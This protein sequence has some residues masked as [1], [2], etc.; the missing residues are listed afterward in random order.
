MAPMMTGAP[1]APPWVTD[2]VEVIVAA[3]ISEILTNSHQHAPRENPAESYGMPL[4]D[5]SIERLSLTLEPVLDLR[6]A[7]S[8]KEALQQGLGRKTPLL[9]DATAVTRMS[10][11]CV[12][13]LTAFVLETQKTGISLSLK[14][15]SAAFDTAFANLGLAATLNGIKTPE[16]T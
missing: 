9:I 7:A 16:L 8:L 5:A 4:P 14:N 10:T 13:V 3:I 6:A 1:L 12:Q 11:A 15:S 2:R